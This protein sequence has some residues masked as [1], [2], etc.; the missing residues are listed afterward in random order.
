MSP[1]SAYGANLA[2]I[3][4]INGRFGASPRPRQ[5][6]SEESSDG[7]TNDSG[8]SADTEA[9]TPQPHAPGVGRLVDKS[10]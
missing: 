7:N 9:E 1:I 5:R 4:A 2:G 6:D 3:Q 8:E 10:A